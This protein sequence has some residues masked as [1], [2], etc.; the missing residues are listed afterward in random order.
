MRQSTVVFLQKPNLSE[1]ALAGGRA[2]KAQALAHHVL[3]LLA[4]CLLCC[5]SAPCGMSHHRHWEFRARCAAASLTLA[6]PFACEVS[7]AA[8]GL[9]CVGSCG[10]APLRH[11]GN[12]RSWAASGLLCSGS[13]GFAP[14]RHRGNSRFAMRGGVEGAVRLCG[15]H[16]RHTPALSSRVQPRCYPRA[17][18]SSPQ[19]P[20]PVRRPNRAAASPFASAGG[21]SAARS[22][23]PCPPL[24]PRELA[25]R[26][27][28]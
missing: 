15:P 5:T 26:G 8:S 6:A 18:A 25:S 23:L 10:C 13:C 21:E 27:Q 24:P 3:R 17:A 28:S 2:T 1:G 4:C 22:P 16:F 19:R 20:A 14:L 9:Y 12:S 11:R 7:R